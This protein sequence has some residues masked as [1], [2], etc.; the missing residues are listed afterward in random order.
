MVLVLAIL[1]A[2]LP[3]LHAHP[4][5][6]SMTATGSGIHLHQ[7]EFG[8]LDHHFSTPT[9]EAFHTATV[10]VGVGNAYEPDP[11]QLPHLD[12]VLLAIFLLVA[13]FFGGSF[14]Q[15]FW[16]EYDLKPTPFPSFF[17]SPLRAPPLA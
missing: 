2:L 7:A 1:Q 10:A 13:L 15:T 11:L 14:H 12:V 3:L 8:G 17:T 4:A 9:F 5:G 16:R 6:T